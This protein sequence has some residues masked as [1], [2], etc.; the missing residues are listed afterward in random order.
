MAMRL[1]SVVLALVVTGLVMVPRAH[2]NGIQC[3][4]ILGPG[5][6][7][8]LDHDL[9]CPADPV[10]GGDGVLL[11][12]EG[13]TLNL[14]GHSV[15]CANKGWGIQVINATL[16]HGTIR[17]CKIAVIAGGSVVK[18]LTL[19]K[20]DIGVAI[21]GEWFGGDNL[22]ANILV[23]KGGAG[24][25]V[26]EAYNNTFIDNIVKDTTGSAAFDI[27]E[28]W[29]DTLTGNVAI[30]NGKGF[31]INGGVR[32]I[33]N[34]A[35]GNGLGFQIE[36][37]LELTGNI[38][39]DNIGVGFLVGP[40]GLGIASHNLAIGNG[41][42]GFQIRIDHFKVDDDADNLV[43]PPPVTVT[44]NYAIANRGKGLHVLPEWGVELDTPQTTISGNTAIGN[45]GGDLADD[46]AC[47][48]TTWQNNR[49][50]TASPACVR[51]GRQRAPAR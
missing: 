21:T 9:T 25:Y 24:F 8:V 13:A 49:F 45:L 42:D 10:K 22:I 29:G 5:G 15:A 36:T 14:N 16:R 26:E 39:R 51:K 31:M 2:G 46:T 7:Y 12:I 19:A 18:H 1:A 33:G 48:W 17:G 3:G 50:G 40:Q 30:R 23:K 11:V 43:D 41:D 6:T 32:L 27:S 34:R 37:A 38:A 20:N 44:N 28:S 4:S 35:E 47:H